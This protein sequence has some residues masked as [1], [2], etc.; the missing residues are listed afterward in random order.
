MALPWRCLRLNN[1]DHI[2]KRLGLIMLVNQQRIPID[3]PK[4]RNFKSR[5]AV[6]MTSWV[7]YKDSPQCQCQSRCININQCMRTTSNYL[8]KI[9]IERNWLSSRKRA[10]TQIGSSLNKD[11]SKYVYHNSRTVNNTVTQIFCNFPYYSV[12]PYDKNLKYI[13]KTEN[14]TQNSQCYSSK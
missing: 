11:G 14:S 3:E 1:N 10:F 12:L 8:D 2:W 4:D 7:I 5:P 6:G 13:C 9:C